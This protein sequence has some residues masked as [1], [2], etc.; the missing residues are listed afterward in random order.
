MN[1]HRLTPG[2][3]DKIATGET[4]ILQIL[5]SSSL[6]SHDNQL[7]ASGPLS[8]WMKAFREWESLVIR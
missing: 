4:D 3:Y 7:R 8:Q 6:H 1:G 5:A 2:S